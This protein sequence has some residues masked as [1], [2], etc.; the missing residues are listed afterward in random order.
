MLKYVSTRGEA[1]AVTASEA[2]LNGIAPDGGLYVPAEWPNLALDWEKLKNQTYQEIATQ[3]FDGF[4]DDF[5]VSEIDHIVTKAYGQ[6]WDDTSI[7]TYHKEANLTYMELFHGPT[8]AFKDVALQAL[9]HLMTTAA[10]IQALTDTMVILTATSGDTGTAA[11]RGFGDVPQ[12]EIV[13]FYPEVGV[14]ALQRQQMQSE[15][16]SNAHVIAITG[17]FDDAQQAVKSL[18]AQRNLVAELHEKNKRFSSANSINI[19]RLVPQIVYYIHAYAKLVQQGRIAA[20]EPVNI[21]VPTGNFGN[22]LAAFYASQIGLPV[23]QFIVAANENNV[24]CDFFNTGRYDRRRDFKVTNAPAM[25]ILV[26]SNLERLLY[27]A[28]GRNTTEVKGYMQALAERGY[29]DLT[30]Q[31][32]QALQQFVSGFATQAQVTQTIR[33][34]FAETQYLIDPHTAVG[35]AVLTQQAPTG[36]TLIAATASPYKFTE[37]VLAALQGEALAGQVGLAALSQYSGTAIPKPVATLFEQPLR[38][39][40]VI[41][42][43]M[44]AQTFRQEIL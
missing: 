25:D 36:P 29:Y 1:P 32:R 34:V 3:I 35:R 23:R 11:M 21:A 31:T 22:V 24:L 37:T 5:S 9:P 38:H 15:P 26:S 41:A 12:T 43:Q 17:N 42:P 13:V 7:V 20:G 14:S 30:A 16:A 39:K 28:S 33:A 44:M 40:Q 19:G 2:I 27:F 4:F 18:L 6:Q 8:L 10:K